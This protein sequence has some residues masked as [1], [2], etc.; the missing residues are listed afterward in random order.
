M[1]RDQAHFIIKGPALKR[2]ALL[3]CSP[4]P[5]L[6]PQ[7]TLCFLLQG[8]AVLPLSPSSTPASFACREPR[9]A[10]LARRKALAPQFTFCIY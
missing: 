3:L 9:L 8:F 5:G 2:F 6:A 1:K 4:N 10:L 7:F